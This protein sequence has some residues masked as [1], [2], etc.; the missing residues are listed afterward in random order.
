MDFPLVPE[1]GEGFEDVFSD[2]MKQFHKDLDGSRQP[3]Y[4]PCRKLLLTQFDKENHLIHFSILKFYLEMGM[5][6]KTVYCI[7]K[8]RQ[9]AFLKPYIDSNS[10]KRAL[11]ENNFERDFYKYKNKT[12]W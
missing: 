9:K 12:F 11:A 2:F 4:K 1:S 7:I 10:Q 5:I 8:F 3:K 6:L